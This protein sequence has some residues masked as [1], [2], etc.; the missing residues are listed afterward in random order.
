[1]KQAPVLTPA[2]QAALAKLGGDISVARRRR[3]LPQ[4][5]VAVRSAITRNTL[6]RVERGHAGVSLGVYAAVLDTLGL[7]ARVADLADPKRDGQEMEEERLPKR[8][9][10]PRF[11]LEPGGGR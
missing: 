7:V 6:G 10:L 2:V 8:V 4:R 5:I 1:M 3:R 11:P 9:C